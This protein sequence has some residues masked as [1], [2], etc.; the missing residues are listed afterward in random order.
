MGERLSTTEKQYRIEADALGAALRD[1]LADL[2]QVH[3]LGYLNTFLE[4]RLKETVEELRED[5]LRVPTIRAAQRS[6]ADYA[7]AALRREIE[8]VTTRGKAAPKASRTSAVHT[9][10]H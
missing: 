4:R 5:S 2:V 7:E 9:R 8:S 6:A 3:G 1:A 10:S